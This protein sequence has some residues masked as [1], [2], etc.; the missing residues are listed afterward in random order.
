ME[1]IKETLNSLEM[2]RESMIQS[3]ESE[4]CFK[5]LR[6]ILINQYKQSLEEYFCYENN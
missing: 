5:K 3:V 6:N 2:I 1:R 4:D